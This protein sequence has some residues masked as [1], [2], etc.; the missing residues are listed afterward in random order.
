MH[1]ICYCFYCI[2]KKWSKLS[3]KTGF[4]A[5][6]DRFF[7]YT[8]LHPDKLHTPIFCQIKHLMLWRGRDIILVNHQCSICGC[9]LINFQIFSC[10]MQ[11]PRNVASFWGHLFL[12]TFWPEVI[13]DKA[14]WVIQTHCAMLNN[15][16]SRGGGLR[17]GTLEVPNQ[18]VLLNFHD[19]F[20]GKLMLKIQTN[21][22][23]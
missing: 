10:L 12:L 3:Q 15:I 22:P 8:L 6:F 4:L 5:Y 11:H 19:A 1:Q 2:I 20:V 18:K 7:D 13:S 9:Q 16:D 21:S 14:S 17:Q 23:H